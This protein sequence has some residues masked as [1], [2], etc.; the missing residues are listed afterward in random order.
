MSHKKRV[1]ASNPSWDQVLRQAKVNWR[2]KK[3]FMSARCFSLAR[4]DFICSIST[5]QVFI[6]KTLS[7][8]LTLTQGSRAVPPGAWA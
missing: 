4:N 7:L 2:K 3:R 5:V 8:N 6:R 1:C